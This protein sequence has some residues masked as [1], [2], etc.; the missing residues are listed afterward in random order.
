MK[1]TEK[2]IK[3]L[4]KVGACDLCLG[5]IKRTDYSNP[6]WCKVQSD[7]NNIIT[8]KNNGPNFRQTV[9]A[10]DKF[11]IKYEKEKII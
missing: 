6:N 10:C 7:A 5:C 9:V 1:Y 2:A 8:L 3:W 11:K 4:V